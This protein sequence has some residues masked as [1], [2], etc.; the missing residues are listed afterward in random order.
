MLYA[1]L[2]YPSEDSS[3]FTRNSYIVEWYF[4]WSGN[5]VGTQKWYRNVTSDL[6]R[7]LLERHSLGGTS[8]FSGYFGAHTSK[9]RRQQQR[10]HQQQHANPPPPPPPPPIYLEYKTRI[11]EKWLLAPD[12]KEDDPQRMEA[13]RF[14][15]RMFR[16][17]TISCLTW[18]EEYWI[19]K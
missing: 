17:L 4:W 7:T 2:K 9:Q 5:A 6:S 13:T 11:Q 1:N 12:K 15:I 19:L 18:T 14:Q 8:K 3:T 10:H 16:N